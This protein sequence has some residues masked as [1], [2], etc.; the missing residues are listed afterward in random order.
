MAAWYDGTAQ[1]LN[2]TDILI[3]KGHTKRPDRVII[4]GKQVTVIDYKFGQKQLRT[5]QQQVQE[6][7][8]LIRKMG[9]PRVEGYLWY[10]ELNK[11][12]PVNNS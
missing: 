4:K 3:G 12:K 11:I 5:H 6:Y 10:V 1:V 9:Y 7:L 2:E 8:Q